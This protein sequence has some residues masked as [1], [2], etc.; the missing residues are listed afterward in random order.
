MD[1]SP[2]RIDRRT[3]LRAG[4]GALALPLL[5]GA[6]A[7]ATD[8]QAGYEPLD[9][10]E[11][12][13]AAEAVVNEDATVAYVAVGSGFVSVDISD[14]SDLSIL[15]DA[16]GLTD[17]DGDS[18]REVLDVK[19]ENDRV[20]VPTAAQNGGPR[21]IFVFDVSDPANP[22]QV[23]D[24]FETPSHGNHN[25]HLVDG[26]AYLTGG[27]DLDIIDVS[28]SSFERL[29]T[30][31]PGD[32]SDEWAEI[33]PNT[34]LHDLY[35]QDGT[36]YCAYWDAGVFLVDVSDPAN[37]SFVGRKGDYTRAELEELS[38]SKYLEPLGNDHYVTVN[39]DA[40]IMVEGG[41]SWDTNPDDDE[42]GPS[43]LE[44]FDISDPANPQKLSAIDA[45][46][47]VSNTYRNGTW[48]TAHNF[49]IRGDRLYASWYQGGVTVHDV[50][51]PENPERIAWWADPDT[52][53]FWTARTAVDGEFY[54][55][56]G[57]QVGGVTSEGLVTFP[58][59]AG[60]MDEVPSDVWWGESRPE[61]ATPTET[62]TVRTEPTPTATETATPTPTA[63]ATETATTEDDASTSATPGFGILATLA[64]AGLAGARLLRQRNRE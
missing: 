17:P 33:P 9:S 54:V 29:A 58:D 37:P 43:G 13:G 25:S 23:G 41:E 38:Q 2:S 12:D 49:E 48:T 28:G 50:S 63:T 44:L 46:N 39:D 51:D 60:E 15:G 18:V 34:V 57:H 24:W 30:W 32:W 42:G 61:T 53:A 31:N 47:S 4:A 3:L 11:L 16:A 1:E 21:G 56:S 40:S 7:G 20:L 35:V 64:G 36:A 26:V 59:T 8:Q 19:Y 5:G 52:Y 14:P 45:P 62:A 55:A 27:Y 6:A 22:E 10:I